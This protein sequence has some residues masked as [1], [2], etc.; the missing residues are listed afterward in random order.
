MDR[1]LG[2][3]ISKMRDGGGLAN[4]ASTL[5]VATV[6]VLMAGRDYLRSRPAG[7]TVSIVWPNAKIFPKI[8]ANTFPVFAD[9]ESGTRRAQMLAAAIDARGVLL[10]SSLEKD[11]EF[12]QEHIDYFFLANCFHLESVYRRT[13]ESSAKK[14]IEDLCTTH[15]RPFQQWFSESLP[16][17]FAAPDQKELVFCFY[18]AFYIETAIRDAISLRCALP[19]VSVEE[20]MASFC[21]GF[22]DFRPKSGSTDPAASS[23]PGPSEIVQISKVPL[24]GAAPAPTAGSMPSLPPTEKLGAHEIRPRQEESNGRPRSDTKNHSPGLEA[25]LRRR[26]QDFTQ[27][28]KSQQFIRGDQLLEGLR[29]SGVFSADEKLSTWDNLFEHQDRSEEWRIL[30][31]ESKQRTASG[32]MPTAYVYLAPRCSINDQIS[33]MFSGCSGHGFDS[34]IAGTRLPACV[35]RDADGFIRVIVKGE[36]DVQ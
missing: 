31:V 25:D 16:T 1:E 13:L 15:Q 19:P 4:S 23:L 35:S 2:D 32:S 14:K 5:E 20:A 27:M 26:A 8:V 17:S 7:D 9:A 28:A 10:S 3:G 6:N 36:A 30:Y 21:A 18:Y 34:K 24:V 33:R 22:A 11:Y 12:A 29:K